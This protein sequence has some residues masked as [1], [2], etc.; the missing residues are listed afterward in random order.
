LIAARSAAVATADA[1]ADVQ[2]PT[3]LLPSR[4]WP[5]LE[6]RFKPISGSATLLV[7]EIRDGIITRVGLGLPK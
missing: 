3:A 2:E 1:G 4:R 6:R 7:R 5:A